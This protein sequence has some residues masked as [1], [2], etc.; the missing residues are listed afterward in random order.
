MSRSERRG[1]SA[2]QAREPFRFFSRSSFWNT[3]L[4][5]EAP[6]DA[7]SAALVGALDT[8]VGEELAAE[9]GPWINTTSY[10]VPIYTVPKD[11]ATVR[12]H[13]A[14]PYSAPGLRAALRAV[15]MLPNGRPAAGTDAHLVIWQPSSDRLWEFWH[16]EHVASG[17]RTGWGGAMDDASSNPG[18]YSSAAWPGADRFWGASA[19]SLS[20]A[21]GLITLEDLSRGEINHA[22]AL[23]VPEPRAGIY[24]SPARRTD[25]TSS[26][27]LSLPEGAHLRLDPHLR[28]S[29]LHLPRVTLLIARA[30]Q[31]YGIF[32]RD[33]ARTVAFSAQAPRSARRDPYAG[34]QG[35]FAGEMPSQLLASF[36]WSHLQ[37]LKMN[38]HEFG[39]HLG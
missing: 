30:A 38:L 34:P 13:L 15:P 3:S 12:V 25:G 1:T 37:V 6:Q 27:P 32:V 21:G 33:K 23:T 14:S 7:E 11:Q 18:V 5:A 29:T 24:A 19:T 35:Y 17:W 36:P 9:T 4:P 2:D 26:N 8:E 22:L 39:P 20:I 28:L 10:S 16:L 31:R